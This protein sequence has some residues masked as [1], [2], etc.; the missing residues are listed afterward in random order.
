MRGAPSGRSARR[1]VVILGALILAGTVA[2]AATSATTPA[3]VAASEELAQAAT[4]GR[5]TGGPP[6]A[7]GTQILRATESGK[8]LEVIGDPLSLAEV[9]AA[10][11]PAPESLGFSAGAISPTWSGCWPPP[12]ASAT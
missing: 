1:F 8:V 12:T 4:A 2:A 6:A 3:E 9:P 11:D 10:T 5:P 7:G